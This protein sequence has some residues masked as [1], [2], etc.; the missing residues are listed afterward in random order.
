M[1]YLYVHRLD[2]NASIKIVSTNK[3]IL[4]LTLVASELMYDSNKRR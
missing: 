1:Y 4:N 2:M 3:Y